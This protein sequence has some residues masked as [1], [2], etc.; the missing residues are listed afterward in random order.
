MIEE[1]ILKLKI[2]SLNFAFRIIIGFLIVKNHYK[3]ILFENRSEFGMSLYICKTDIKKHN[4]NNN[5]KS[6][7]MLT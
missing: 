5:E 4:K 6:Y 2:V 1:F 3:I 7:L